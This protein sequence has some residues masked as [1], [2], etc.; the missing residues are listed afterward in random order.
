MLPCLRNC[1]LNKNKELL[2]GLVPGTVDAKND[3][4][5]LS[6]GTDKN[7]APTE[8]KQKRGI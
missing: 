7:R 3:H 5:D 8:Q 6:G 2:F 1:V 4:F